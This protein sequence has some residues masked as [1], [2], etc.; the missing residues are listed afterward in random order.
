VLTGVVPIREY[1]APGNLLKIIG[2]RG[3]SKVLLNKFRVPYL[4]AAPHQERVAQT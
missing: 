3:I 4:H 2:V 1:F